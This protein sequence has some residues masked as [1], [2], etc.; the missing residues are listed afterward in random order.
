VGI[1]VYNSE[2]SVKNRP[3]TICGLSECM[4]VFLGGL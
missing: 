2:W 3:S 1:S 4:T